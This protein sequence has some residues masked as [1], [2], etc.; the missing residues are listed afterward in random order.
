L[1]APGGKGDLGPINHMFRVT[2]NAE[3][4][5]RALRPLDRQCTHICIPLA[6]ADAANSVNSGT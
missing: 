6:D 1:A 2:T 3:S 4:F 5:C